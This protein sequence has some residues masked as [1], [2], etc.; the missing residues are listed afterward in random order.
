MQT[1]QEGARNNMTDEYSEIVDD[2]KDYLR[3]LREIGKHT[4]AMAAPEAAKSASAKSVE[5][6]SDSNLVASPECELERIAAEIAKCEACPLHRTR[7]NVVPGEG[8]VNPD[9][10]FIGEGPGRDEDMQGLPFVG[11]SGEL[12][13]RLIK[14][15]GYTRKQV[16][17]GNIVKCRPTVDYRMERDRA[18]NEDE[19]R[20]CIHFLK[21]QISVIQPKVIV[22]LGNTAILGLFGL[23]GI[24]KLRGRWLEYEGIPTMPT[25]HPSFLLRGGGSKGQRF[26]EVWEDMLAV[27]EKLGR[28]PPSDR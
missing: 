2:L 6:H 13:D 1:A 7:S 10:M 25:Y 21:A 26:W 28:E 8:A 11:R 14:R 22:A 5:P 3:H 16:F 27:F 15:M 4:I 17:I 20:A 24:T 19:M 12:L 18:P 23:T 9:I